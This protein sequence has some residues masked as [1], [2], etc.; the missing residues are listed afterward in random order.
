MIPKVLAFSGA[1]RTGSTLLEILL[2]QQEEFIAVG[3]MTRLWFNGYHKNILCGSRVPVRESELWIAVAE[4]VFGGLE[5]VDGVAISRLSVRN[6]L[7]AFRII[8]NTASAETMRRVR[9]YA[10]ILSK[11]Y[12][13]IAKISNKAVIVDASKDTRHVCVLAHTPGIDL[14]LLHLVRDSRAVVYSWSQRQRRLD[15][16]QEKYIYEPN[17][18]VSAMKWN[19][20]NF[21]TELLKRRHPSLFIR[22][23]DYVLDIEKVLREIM[24]FTGVNV[25]TV[26][27]QVDMDRI[28]EQHGIWGN[29][30]RFQPNIEIKFDARWQREMSSLDR[31][32]STIFTFPL[33]MRYQY[34][35][36]GNSTNT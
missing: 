7:E 8:T 23:E 4:E 9:E 24:H 34:A 20:Q 31:L 17:I 19:V 25:G 12:Q 16:E 27:T 10:D 5:R 32:I 35:L 11:T 13:A 36:S 3:E 6:L 18:I 28:T 15:V 2:G 1:G 26:I 14:K 29:P 30:V 21:Y 33:L 22:Y